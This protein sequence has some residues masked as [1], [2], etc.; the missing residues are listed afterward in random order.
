V[1]AVDIGGNAVRGFFLIT[2]LMFVSGQLLA[3]E[4]GTFNLETPTSL[5]KGQ[6]EFKVQHRFRRK[7]SEQPLGMDQGVNVGISLRYSVMPNFELNA[8]RFWS[9]KEGILGASYAYSIPKSPLRSQ[10]GAQF[11]SFEVFDLEENEMRRENGFFGLLSLQSEPLFNR[12]NPVAN[13]GYDS[14]NKEFGAGLGLNIVILEYLGML[15]RM[16]VVGEYF[17]TGENSFAFGFRFETYGHHFD[18]IFSRNSE[19]GV[20]RLMSGTAEVEG[21]RFGF[22]IKRH[23]QAF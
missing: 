11:F 3:Y 19:N 1:A 4:M 18:F 13:A 22:N 12:I 16:S 23:V 5:E 2:L 9:G 6:G 17:P 7:L 15:Q 10:F 21:M 14:Y 20:R 8:S